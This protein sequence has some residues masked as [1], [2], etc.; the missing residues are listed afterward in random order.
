MSL[1]SREIIDISPRVHSGIAVFPGDTPFEQQVMMDV[2]QGDHLSL[3]WIKTTTHV[4]AHADA[5]NHYAKGGA[6]IESRSL[7]PYLGAV[8]VIDVRLPR[9]ERIRVKDLDSVSIQAPRVIF[10]TDSF[11]DPDRWVDDFNALSAELVDHLA[12]Q[13]VILVGID[14]PSIDPANDKILES[15]GA[16]A[17]N[18]M[19]ILEGL[20]LTNVSA[21][22]YDLIALPLNLQNG[23]ASPVRAVLLR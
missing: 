6:T 3:S 20:V 9:G 21:G 14:T 7:K 10:R 16:V 2:N 15:H 1:D 22:R 5:P 11:L 18:D 13:G 17:R 19:S 8:Q 4:G 12:T 23:D